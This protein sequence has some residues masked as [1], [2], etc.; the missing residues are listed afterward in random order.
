MVGLVFTAGT[1]SMKLFTRRSIRFIAILSVAMT[2]FSAEASGIEAG[3]G[4]RQ[5]LGPDIWP[6][7]LQDWSVDDGTIVAIAG[8]DR[9]AHAL[10]YWLTGETLSAPVKATVTVDVAAGTSRAGLRLGVRSTLQD[11]RAALFAHGVGIDAAIDARGALHLDTQTKA[12]PLK[13]LE[14]PVVLFL[15]LNPMTS[16]QTLVR[17]TATD[18]KGGQAVFE[19]RLETQ[20]L[21]G[22]IALL[23]ESAFEG[24]TKAESVSR[25]PKVRFKNWAVEGE[26]LAQDTEARLGPI[27]WSQYTLSDRRLT[28][29]AQMPP[30]GEQD[31]KTVG[32]ELADPNV[33]TGWREITRSDFDTDARVAVFQIP[34][35]DHDTPTRARLTYN[36][37]GR[38]H[39]WPVT[40]RPELDSDAP[41]KI[42]VMSCDAGYAFPQTPLVDQVLDQDPDLV[43]FAGDQ[44]YE[45]FGG[46]GVA[47]TEPV[48][49]AILDYLR[50][51]MQFG[52]TWREV[53]R[54]RPS[55][56]IPDDHDVFH[57]NIWGAGGRLMNPGERPV[58]GGYLMPVRF[59]NAVQ[60]T[61][62]AHLPRA[63]DPTPTLSGIGVY[64]TAM[65]MG[66]VDFA[67]IEDRKWKVG[68]GTIEGP[69]YERSSLG[70]APLLGERQ[71]AFLA[72][73]LENDAPFK[74][75]LSQTMFARPATHT[76]IK[77]E[78][79]PR[80]PDANGWPM[81]A[82]DRA[83]RL[84]GPDTIMIA[85]DQHL[86]ML[87]RL[88]IDTWD[89]GPVAFMVPGSANGHP[90]AWWPEVNLEGE[91][92]A[93]LGY[94][95]RYIDGLGNNL[96]VLGVANPDSGSHKLRP[97]STGPYALARLKGSGYGVATF[98]PERRQ[99]GFTLLRFPADNVN[100]PASDPEP[101]TG[102][103][104]TLP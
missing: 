1:L 39:T 93:P 17:L 38:L 56:I 50:K 99:V 77:L 52:W 10:G 64:Y 75:V 81:P 59:V 34:D 6:N 12:T 35:W 40:I 19:R 95:G 100:G 66:P 25:R 94:T 24:P 54:D 31:A 82:R 36:W 30:L 2:T 68:P 53:L 55:V 78:A 83:L 90:R 61:Q 14:G 28:L 96:R 102:F 20:A 9:T 58:R 98:D 72:D 32:L 18:H 7:P 3:D 67:I 46:F 43:F 65:R 85:G 88:G 101:F 51:Y 13:P 16:G 41:V 33:A 104:M 57:G 87:A 86:G 22:N 4:T 45:H 91:A 21:T 84:L 26:S 37:Q 5:W 60:R 48:E 70:D 80:D 29:S 15:E 47:R 73:W 44:I 62:T 92:A 89:D 23:A 74:V 27:L 69:L 97:R 11:H 42:A 76:G 103:P 49:F 8:Q 79:K 63:F 71:E